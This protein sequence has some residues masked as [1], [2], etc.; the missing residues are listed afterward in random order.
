NSTV[1]L[2][3][4]TAISGVAT[5]QGGTGD[6][7]VTVSAGVTGYAGTLVG[8]GGNDTVT[9]TNGTNAWSITAANTATLNA[10]TVFSGFGTLT[11]GSGADSFT[12]ASGVASFVGSLAGGGGTDTLAATNGSNSWNLLAA[13]GGTLNTDTLFSGFES[14]AGG[15]GA[16]SFVLA[17]GLSSFA[18]S[19]SGGSGTDTL[20]AT[21]G[22]NSWA[23]SA[24]NAGTL[25]TSTSFSGI[26]SL[27]GGTGADGFTLATAVTSFVGTLSGGG[28]TDTLA[29][30][31]GTNAWALSAANTGTL[32]TTTAFSGIAS[33][34]GG[35]GNDTFT[36]AS[37]LASFGGSL[38]GGS[39]GTDALVATDGANTWQISASNTGTLNSST[40]FSAIDS[41]AGGSG[42]DDFTLAA[43]VSTLA[44]TISGG[45]GSD[46]VTATNGANSWRL[47]GSAAGTLNTTTVISNVGNWVGG[48]GADT[49]NGSNTGTAYSVTGA[50]G[51]SASGVAMSSVESVAGGTGADSFTMAAGVSTFSG[52]LNGGGG[53]DT[54]AASN[55]LNNTWVL[56]ANGAGSLNTSTSFSNIETITGSTGTDSLTGV[57]SGSSY[58]IT[59]AGAFTV[60]GIAFSGFDAVTGG[61]GNDTFTFNSGVSS[62]GGTLGGGGGTNTLAS[63]GGTT[64]NWRITGANAGTLNTTTAFTGMQTLSGGTGADNF[65]GAGGSLSGTLT[66]AAGTAG[67]IA[68]T[69]QTGGQ[70]RYQAATT[71][72]ADAT[73]SATTGD[74]RF[75]STLNGAHDLGIST[76]GSGTTRFIG[77]VGGTT[78]L[79]SLTIGSSGST[80]LTASQ[81]R[82]TG[83][84]TWGN[85][86]TATGGSLVASA[87]NITAS[88]G[89]NQLSGTITATGQ[90]VSLRSAGSF[91]AAL[92][93]SGN[94]TLRAGGTL[95]A[96]GAVDGSLTATSGTSTALGALTVGG[97]ASLAAPGGITQSANLSVAGTLSVDVDSGTVTLDRAGNDFGTVAVTQAG[98]ATIT[99]ANSMSVGSSAVS[100]TL[101]LSAPGTI[102]LSGPVSGAAALVKQGSGTMLVASAQSYSGGTQIDAGT[103][104]VQGAG[105]LGSGAVDVASGT[106]LDLRSGAAM[107]NDVTLDG[108]RLVTSAGNASLNGN[109]TLNAATTVDV[110]SGS[111]LTLGG[112]VGDGAASVGL[113]KTGAGTLALNGSASFDGSFTVSNGVLAVGSSGLLNSQGA[114]VVDAA[115]GVTLGSAQSVGSLAGAGQVDLQ[116]QRLTVGAN[117]ASTTFSGDLLSTGTATGGLTKVGS[118]NLTLSGSASHQGST[119]VLAGTLTAASSQALSAGSTVNVAAGATLDLDASATAGALSGEGAVKLDSFTLTAGGNGAS[120]SFSGSFSGGDASQLV[121]QG[122]GTLS[123][124]GSSS[125]TGQVTV[126]AGTLALASAGA[127]GAMG[128]QVDAGTTLALQTDASIGSLAGAGQ[129]GLGSH[130]LEAGA[131]QA[132]TTFSGQVSGD[133]ASALVKTG[134][135]T[136]TLSGSNAVLGTTRAAQ[137]VLNLA[138]GAAVDDSATLSV[139]SGARVNLA[140]DETVGAL[141]GAGAVTLAGATLTT[142]ANDAAATFSG[143]ISGSG[144]LT[145]VGS[146]VQ[147]LSGNN[148]Y[149]GTTTVSAGTLQVGAGGSS[150]TLGSGAVVN[151]ATLAVN[152]SDALTMANPIS[153][154]GQ[155][156]LN[157]GT[158]T[159]SSAANSY[160]GDT[161]V[162]GG[163]LKTAGAERLPD[164]TDL[165]VSAPGSVVLGGNETVASINAAGPVT[166]AGNITTAGDQT[167]QN[168]LILNGSS[169][170]TLSGD[171]IV[172]TSGANDLGSH[173]VSIQARQ[174]QL[175]NDKAL[176]L[177]EVTLAE[178]GSVEAASLR[179]SGDVT[180]QGGRTT[181]TATGK[182]DDA[183]SETYGDGTALVPTLSN[184]KLRTAQGMVV[185]DSGTAITVQTNATLDVAA[186][187]GGSIS[188]ASDANRFDGALSVLSGPSFGTAWLPGEATFE[189]RT[190]GVQSFI[191]VAGSTVHLGGNGIEGDLVQVRADQLATQGSSVI[192]A[193]LPYD[194]VVLGTLNSA[195]SLTMIL[196]EGAY[197]ISQ[198]FGGVGDQALRVAVGTR[199]TGNR[200]TGPNAGFL[201]IRPKGGARGS[202]AIFLQGQ[203][204]VLTDPTGYRLFHD[205]AGQQNEIPVIYNQ[206][207]PETPQVSGALSSVAAV[208]EEARRERFEETVRT[209]NVSVRLRSGVIAEVGPGSPATTGTQGAKPPEVCTPGAGMACEEAPRK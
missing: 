159:L 33:L 100:G 44:G 122:S 89:T 152:R 79:A 157:Q 63:T 39:G 201:T 24:A 66:D 99:D 181:L 28:G 127:V 2:N 64:Y 173:P 62:F 116:G 183:K 184:A 189:G 85:A 73:L 25:N 146:G 143:A 50:N 194:D 105:T 188:L 52:A 136:L 121:K 40:A 198:S 193:R 78:A 165:V 12:L 126:A 186:T 190:V 101:T 164:A 55:G 195:P 192:T 87:G 6:D 180:L 27:A 38:S 5:L 114:L 208:S 144:G 84:Q 31:N 191:N 35:S 93:A 139:D 9:A 142:G 135:G 120:T 70:Q 163:Q 42:N 92:D 178:G 23:I 51:V 155:L 69:I 98:V 56:S 58:A 86:L 147:V 156:V 16:D 148:S 21:D 166:A 30:T 81:V 94:A 206:L 32:N 80:V 185:Q 149:S 131:N 199:A 17:S 125:A 76:G 205:G 26:E 174:V 106:T 97:S 117:N 103:V 187:Q 128:V 130:T 46:S 36:L 150:G 43:G 22:S 18:G 124:A 1:T 196:G 162:R 203:E 153:G 20:A 49:L 111:T 104:A 10:T 13:G 140:T 47:T 59:G 109:L 138:G 132:S 67:S 88:Q 74:I 118:G 137:G 119:Q 71:L 90:D 169:G 110:A 158:L 77:D 96:R 53:N 134:A 4:S 7:S 179:L 19:L 34:T 168:G 72:A 175:A 95:G 161:L 83:N 207:L 200:T 141:V 29:A 197:T 108:G 61:A 115:G 14:L 57:A 41:L 60:S 145:K 129:V 102:T 171:V 172:A 176:V 177:G 204:V 123:L 209:E 133:A 8:G 82:T 45:G 112:P 54:L 113:T 65:T 160:T 154:A 167:Y 11:G 182:P 170:Q 151:Q 37:G 91:T 15:T 75:D 202:T 68:G 3:S 48:S 107:P